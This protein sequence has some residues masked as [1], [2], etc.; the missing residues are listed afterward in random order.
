MF[1]INTLES[2][3][4]LMVSC[5]FSKLVWDKVFSWVGVNRYVDS[6]V[7]PHQLKFVEVLKGSEG[8]AVLVSNMLDNMVVS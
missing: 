1:C 4:H 7:V 5:P 3:D 2:L 6:S 8:A